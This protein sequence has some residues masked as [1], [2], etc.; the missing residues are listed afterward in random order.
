LIFSLKKP[1]L[2]RM[3]VCHCNGVTD[4]RI[5]GAVRAG[6]CSLREVARACGAGGCC[7]GCRPE[8]SRILRQEAGGQ[9]KTDDRP[10][11]SLGAPQTSAGI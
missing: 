7:G 2:L 9:A 10:S 5:R 6:A 1:M 4:H 3:L 8:I 11:P